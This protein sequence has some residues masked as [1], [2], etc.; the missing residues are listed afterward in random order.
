MVL[1]GAGAERW[2]LVRENQARRGG[3]AL[4]LRGENCGTR[5]MWRGA[6]GRGVGEIRS[7]TDPGPA[8]GAFH[9][10]FNSCVHAAWSWCQTPGE[11]KSPSTEA[12]M[13]C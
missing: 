10:E 7:G 5:E 6:T 2:P 12:V 3:G 8:V 13:P 4:G 11:V 9:R 1:P